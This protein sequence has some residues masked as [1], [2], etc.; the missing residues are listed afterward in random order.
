MKNNTG[1]AILILGSIYL[2]IIAEGWARWLLFLFVGLGIATWG[3]HALVQEAEELTKLT[4]QKLKIEIELMK[5][6]V[7][8]YVAQGLAIVRRMG[9]RQ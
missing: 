7:K 6:Q 8:M 9:R 5:A 1:E 3:K 2:F 4:T